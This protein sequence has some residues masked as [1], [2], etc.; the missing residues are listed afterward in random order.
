M[1]RGI[2]SALRGRAKNPSPLDLLREKRRTPRR[3]IEQQLII[4]TRGQA[5]PARCLDQSVG[6]VRFECSATETIK[7]GD[8]LELS[9]TE[10]A[11]RLNGK[12]AWVKA[13]GA[14]K[15]VGVEREG[16]LDSTPERRQFVRFHP[17]LTVTCDN[18]HLVVLDVSLRGMR[19]RSDEPVKAGEL[20][21]DLHLPGPPMQV[22]A[23][24][25]EGG[26]TARL[27][28]MPMEDDRQQRLGL[29]LAGVLRSGL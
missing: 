20:S 21:L 24:V 23:A 9:S 7:P 25:L 2:L 6:G 29:F 4:R 10:R 5:F 15:Q 8:H 11:L 27:E 28:L 18:H 12:V 3:A 14:R 22:Q 16:V 19:V 1:L 26:R 13:N 17:P